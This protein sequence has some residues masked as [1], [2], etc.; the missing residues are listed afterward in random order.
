LHADET[1]STGSE[2]PGGPATRGR[3]V[4]IVWLALIAA[5]VVGWLVS[6]HGGT[7][8]DPV[9]I[10]TILGLAA[11]KIYLVI[12][13]FMG[14]RSAGIEWRLG[15]VTWIIGTFAAVGLVIAGWPS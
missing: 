12:A 10:A 3:T 5:T 2:M 14:L 1:A 13:L 11:I 6:G 4:T 8:A 7:G 15:A 9:R